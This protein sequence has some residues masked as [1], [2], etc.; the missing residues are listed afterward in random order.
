MEGKVFKTEDLKVD[1]DSR[2]GE[3]NVGLDPGSVLTPEGNTLSPFLAAVLMQPS[4]QSLYRII[5][6][7]GYKDNKGLYTREGVSSVNGMYTSKETIRTNLFK[8]GI[9]IV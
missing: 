3:L 8:L 5:L 4:D 1:L 7:K 9:T 6:Q 2:G